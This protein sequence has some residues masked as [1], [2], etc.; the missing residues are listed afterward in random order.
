MTPASVAS[1]NVKIT[2][3]LPNAL[4]IDNVFNDATGGTI[5]I[6]NVST[7]TGAS[8]TVVGTV[9]AVAGNVSLTSNNLITVGGQVQTITGA[10]TSVERKGGV[11]VSGTGSVSADT[12]TITIDADSDLSSAGLFTNA[13]GIS[14]NNAT[15]SQSLSRPSIWC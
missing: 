13:G 14:T 3:V 9:R 6:E 7:A 5:T 2:Q 15:N 11:Q 4:S 8:I 10:A 12:G 1:G